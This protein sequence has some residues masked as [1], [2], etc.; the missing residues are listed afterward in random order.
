MSEPARIAVVGAGVIG[1][2]VAHALAERG[3]HVVLIDT[4][5]AALDRARASIRAGI[6]LARLHRKGPA[7][8]DDLLARVRFTTEKS[9]LA[10]VDLVIE[11]VTEDLEIKLAVHREL[12]ALCADD[13][14]VAVNTS[15]ISISKLAAASTRPARLIGL[16]F[17]NPVPLTAMVEVVRGAQTSDAT[18]ARVASLL[19]SFRSVEG[20]RALVERKRSR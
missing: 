7:P 2:S 4:D 9:D 1:A 18:L 14:V 16:H 15:A 19:A 3:L 10:A 11:N 13:C 12:D 20:M 6:R 8:P 5:A 17:M